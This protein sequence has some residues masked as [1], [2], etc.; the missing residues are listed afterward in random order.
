MP[1]R[2]ATRKRSGLRVVS[3]NG[4]AVIESVSSEAKLLAAGTGSLLEAITRVRS[5]LHLSWCV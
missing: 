1:N 3:G 2:A 4:P 5:P